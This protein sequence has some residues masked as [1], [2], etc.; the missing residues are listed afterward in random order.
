[1]ANVV[2]IPCLELFMRQDAAYQ[3]Q[4]L[5]NFPMLVVEAGSTG[6]WYKLVRGQGTVL[7]IDCF[8][9]SAKAEDLFTHFG[10]TIAH[11]VAAAKSL[12]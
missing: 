10:L 8:G 6:L 9:E 7:G 5:Q 2:S 4:V 1:M 11:V 12:T 3:K